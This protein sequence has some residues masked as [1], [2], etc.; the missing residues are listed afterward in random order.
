MPNSK[1]VAGVRI[2]LVG[3][4]YIVNPT[5]KE[6]EESELDLLLAGTDNAILMIEVNS[7]LLFFFLMFNFSF[8]YLF[9]FHFVYLTDKWMTIS[10][11]LQFIFLIG[12]YFFDRLTGKLYKH[13]VGFELMALPFTHSYVI[14]YISIFRKLGN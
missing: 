13:V 14:D 5:S 10:I 3:D 9:I 8:V 7:L 4:K 2:G 6:M 1:A 12:E 11:Y